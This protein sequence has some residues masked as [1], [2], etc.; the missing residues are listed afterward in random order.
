M[1]SFLL[2]IWK[3]LPNSEWLKG[4]LVWLITQK[5]L[6]GVVGVVPNESGEIL[7]LKHTYRDK[8]QWGLPGGSLKRGEDP[9]DALSREILEET[10]M[11]VKVIKPLIVSGDDKWP[12]VD[13]VFLCQV[14][15]GTFSASE[16]VSSARF[17]GQD[18][19]PDVMPGQKKIIQDVFNK[20]VE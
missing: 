8:Y 12:R 9:G 3:A 2:K 1:K 6:V 5:F 4:S 11:T 17:F 19:L 14:I 20:K 13:L 7:L 18:N 16:E 15:D 10:G